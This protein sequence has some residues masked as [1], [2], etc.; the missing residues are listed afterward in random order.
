[1][2]KKKNKNIK[3]KETETRSANLPAAL[4]VSAN[5]FDD[6][7]T[8]GYTSLDQNPEIMTAVRRIAEIVGSVSI[9]LM[10][11]TDKGD[12]RIINELS[13]K[14]DIDPMPT[15]TRTHWMQTIVQNL[16]LYG[17]GNSIVLPHTYQGNIKSLEP[18][19]AERVSFQPGTNRYRDYKVLIDRKPHEP[20]DL[21]HF[22][23]NPDQK[24]LWKGKGVEAILKDVANGLKQEAATK[25]GFMSSKWKPSIIVK[26]D[27]MTEEFSGKSGRSKLLEE[28]VTSSSAGEPWL[29][30]AEQF[31]IEQVKPLSLT[32]LAIKDGV[33]MDKRTVASIFGIPAFLLGVGTFNRDEWNHAVQ[34]T[35]GS[36]IKTIEQEMSRKLIINP[37]WYLKM[38]LLSMYDF[39]LQSL[40]GMSQLVSLGI[41]RRNE[42]RDRLG[43][44][45]VEGGDE[46]MV[47]ENYLPADQIGKQKKVSGN[48]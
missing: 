29:I 18:I 47:L 26:V 6:L 9:H 15:M 3:L 10:S 42:M 33:E 36:I 7:C 23:Y 5:E 30:P 38:N 39:D 41:M 25:N 4:F 2:A 11:N 37:K 31:S 22:V 16:L 46:L 32:D 35:I 12:E 27:G 19:A 14:I 13:R 48:D 17:K 28:Y 43:Y 1:M 8:R 45:P 20:E 24:Y 40:T 34:T 44:S 21:L